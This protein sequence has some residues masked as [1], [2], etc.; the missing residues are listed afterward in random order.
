MARHRC[1][2]SIRWTRSHQ[3][4]LICQADCF[5]LGIRQGHI[6]STVASSRNWN[7]FYSPKE[8]VHRN[9]Y[10]GSQKWAHRHWATIIYLIIRLAIRRQNVY[11]KTKGRQ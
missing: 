5:K 4:I 10:I 7:I 2:C 6:R 1:A 8:L 9:N 3:R 11:E